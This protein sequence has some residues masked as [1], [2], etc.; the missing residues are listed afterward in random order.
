MVL[1]HSV[2]WI[3]CVVGGFG[4]FFYCG[5]WV[6]SFYDFCCGVG[7]VVVVVYL[8]VCGMFLGFS[9][10]GILVSFVCFL[11][12]LCFFGVSVFFVCV[13]LF[14]CSSLF[15][16]FVF[17]SGL[18]W[19]LALYFFVGLLFGFSGYVVLEIIVLVHVLC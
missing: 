1:W 9:G 14:F 2:F 6:G 18:F 12:V 4:V 11:V 17:L 8:W 19:G 10:G 16:R 5:V 7:G 3:L 13:C 15:F